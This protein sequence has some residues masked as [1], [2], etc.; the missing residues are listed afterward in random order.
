MSRE[1]PIAD[2]LASPAVDLRMVLGSIGAVLLTIAI[3]MGAAFWFLRSQVPY[4]IVTVPH[5]F[6]APRQLSD[7]IDERERIQAEQNRNLQSWTWIDRKNGIVSIPIEDAM[8]AIAA[9]GAGAYA[10]I[11]RASPAA[12]TGG[13]R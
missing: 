4:E 2:G 12:E 11:G 7:E 9:R 1:D 10:P 5:E 13:A 6:P 8:R 3:V